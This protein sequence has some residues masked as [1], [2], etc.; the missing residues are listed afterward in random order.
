MLGNQVIK[1]SSASQEKLKKMYH[2][3]AVAPPPYAT[4]SAKTPGFVVTIYQSGKVM[5]QGKDAETEAVKWGTPAEKKQ[6]STPNTILPEGFSID[7]QDNKLSLASEASL[8]LAK[9]ANKILEA[10][11]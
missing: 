1:L 10:K 5:F 11:A 7:L 9:S 6:A 8:L 4:F 3:Y 2:E